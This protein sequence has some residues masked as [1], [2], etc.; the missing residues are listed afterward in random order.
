MVGAVIGQRDAA[1]FA[2]RDISTV[3]TKKTG[4]EP[5]PVQEQD[6]LFALFKTIDEFIGEEGG[7]R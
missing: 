5:T 7:D 3:G 1:M 2:G 4:G 6:A